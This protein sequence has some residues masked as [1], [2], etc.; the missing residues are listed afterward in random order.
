MPYVMATRR[1]AGVGKLFAILLGV[2]GIFSFNFLL[3]FVAFFVYVGATEEERATAIDVSLQGIRVKNI[4]SSDVR[5]VRPGLTLD[6]L[7]EHMFREKH[8][9]YPVVENEAML[10]IITLSDVQ[11]VPEEQRGSATVE[12]LMTR[13]LYVIGPEE[14]ASAAM[15]MMNELGIHRLPV[16]ESNRLMGI[17]SRE[18]LV[19]AIELSGES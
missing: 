14:E 15:K 1:A 4:M 3:L 8:R 5:T 10:G 19:R 18:D 13:K 9:G 12:Q 2:L 16:M 6:E 17:V 7:V 11:K